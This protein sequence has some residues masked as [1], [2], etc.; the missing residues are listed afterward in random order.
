LVV[1]AVAD[2]KELQAELGQ[3]HRD[4]PAVIRRRITRVLVAVEPP[5]LGCHTEQ[6]P[7]VVLV[8]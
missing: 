1:V 5:L 3:H 4:I 7:M 6:L 2:V 8:L